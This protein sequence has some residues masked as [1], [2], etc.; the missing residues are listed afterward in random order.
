MADVVDRLAAQSGRPPWVVASEVLDC[1]AQ[2]QPALFAAVPGADAKRW[3]DSFVWQYARA[4]VP[5]QSAKQ[6]WVV[7][8]NLKAPPIPAKPAVPLLAGWAGLVELLRASAAK[9]RPLLDAL[10]RPLI[11]GAG[12]AAV[13]WAWACQV[14]PELAPAA[15][16]LALA[17]PAEASAQPDQ[18]KVAKRFEKKLPPDGEVLRMWLELEK[19]HGTRATG[20]LAK[21]LEVNRSTVIRAL[22]RA[23]APSAV[24]LVNAWGNRAR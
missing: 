9:G 24:S 11:K 1:L 18:A 12:P 7:T 17:N 14:W 8:G 21:R 3:P 2:R 5:A 6:R 10:S 19:A 20:K 4:A 16:S 15:G 13:A 23:R 22:G